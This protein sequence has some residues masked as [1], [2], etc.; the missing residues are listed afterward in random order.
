MSAAHAGGW[1]ALLGLAA[2]RTAVAGL[3]CCNTH[4]LQPSTSTCSAACRHVTAPALTP[5]VAAAT[6]LLESRR[7]NGSKRL[8][9]SRARELL[10]PE[11]VVA[12]LSLGESRDPGDE[13][14]PASQEPHSS[15]RS[16]PP[17]EE[18]PSEAAAAAAVAVPRPNES[19][20]GDSGQAG[21]ATSVISRGRGV[22]CSQD[23]GP[24]QLAL[25][26]HQQVRLVAA[27]FGCLHHPHESS[28]AWLAPAVH[29]VVIVLA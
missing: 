12:A 1:Q 24:A 3:C 17:A 20:E 6:P 18:L 5:R 13:A 11:E 25:A 19:G 16:Q 4:S 7:L 21:A 28:A 27:H 9:G 22:S 14:A 26:A 2:S 10:S 29:Q 23:S 8:K 15:S